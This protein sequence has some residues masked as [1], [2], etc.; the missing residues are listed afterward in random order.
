MRYIYTIETINAVSEKHY[1]RDFDAFTNFKDC[2]EFVDT[3]CTKLCRKFNI[4]VDNDEELNPNAKMGYYSNY[5]WKNT[6]EY[7]R[8]E[9]E[10]LKYKS[11]VYGYAECKLKTY[12]KY[13]D[14]YLISVIYLRIDRHRIC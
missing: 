6:G 14:K 3:Y 8:R 2:K 1:E 7:P 13:E 9:L 5:N 12:L 11:R 4:Q 10:E